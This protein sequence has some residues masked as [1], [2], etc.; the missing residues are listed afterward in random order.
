[1][2]TDEPRPDPTTVPTKRGTRWYQY[3][4]FKLFVFLT[5]CGV[6]L[7]I[8][9][10]TVLGPYRRNQQL[11]NLVFL[12]PPDGFAGSCQREP[13]GPDWARRWFGDRWFMRITGVQLPADKWLDPRLAK[14]RGSPDLRRVDLIGSEPLSAEVIDSLARVPN[15]TSL[16]LQ[17]GTY[18]ADDLQVLARL[19]S[20]EE[21]SLVGQVDDADLLALESLSRLTKL[22]CIGNGSDDR[23]VY[24]VNDQTEVAFTE[25]P[26]RDILDYL[27]DRNQVGFVIDQAAV[28]TAGIKA[29]QLPLTYNRRG[30][31]LH[32][33]LDDLLH[34]VGLDWRIEGKGIT[35][36]TRAA[37]DA[38]RPGL[39]KLRQSLPNLREV[40][41]DW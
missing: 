1:M 32:Q 21:L 36:T 34:P 19:S 14:L 7:G 25:T 28:D 31:P 18:R 16:G 23:T 29:A 40:I 9:E 4:L 13:I 10:T 37:T 20:L 35:V 41:V 22:T 33:A 15:L 38:A 39:N 30:I 2:A 24:A 26:L 27:E 11:A 8:G 6:L 12:P 17:G 5:L 3:T